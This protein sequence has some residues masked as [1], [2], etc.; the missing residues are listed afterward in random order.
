VEVCGVGFTRRRLLKR[1]L[2]GGAAIVLPVA[3]FARV[4]VS[5]PSDPTITSPPVDR[6]AVPLP[7]P[8]T[9]RPS[10][11]DATTNTDFYELTERAAEVEILPGLP[12]TIWGYNGITPG[13]TFDTELGRI[14]RVTIDNQLPDP[15]STHLHG[16]VTPPEFDGHPLLLVPP[17]TRFT[18][19]YPGDNSAATLWYHDHAIHQTGRHVYMGLAGFFLIRDAAERALEIPK[20]PPFEVPLVIQDRLFNADGSLFYPQEEDGLPVRQGAFGDVILVNGA[21]FPFLEVEQRKYRFRLLNGSNARFYSLELSSGEPIT[22]IG[23]DGGFLP[24]PVQ[25]RSLFMAQAERYDIV[26]DFAKYPV[27][28]QIVLRNTVAPDP[29]GD[30]VDP[31]LIREVMRFDV[32]A[33]GP[34]PDFTVPTTIATGPLPDPNAALLTRRFVFER[35]HGAWVINGNL[36]D[37]NR[38]DAF[39]R[40]GTTEIWELVN[41]SGGWL[42]PIHIHL[43]EFKVLDRNGRPPKNFETGPKDV[44]ALG[45]NETIRVAMT[46]AGFSGTYVFHCHN[47]EHEDHDMMGQFHTQ[48]A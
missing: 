42:H 34:A 24:T 25:T 15:T 39:P 5:S 23:S 40:L 21:P 13:P 16:G 41:K 9:I 44:I 11:T 38:I 27:G 32:V 18:H 2:I 37:G 36:F 8:P 20:G 30:P 33:K 3:Q 14:S 26:I 12:T 22:V 48:P 35:R 19:I 17:G 28:T 43:I 47:L 4:A 1:G 7:I 31:A 45:P 29:F 6:F 10:A 46:W